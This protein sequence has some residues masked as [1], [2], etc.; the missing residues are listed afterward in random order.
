MKLN[1]IRKP[2]NINTVIVETLSSYD[3]K[4]EILTE[5]VRDIIQDVANWIERK[6]IKSLSFK[7]LRNGGNHITA[8]KV[9]DRVEVA[10]YD[11]SGIIDVKTFDSLNESETYL[12]Q[13][14]EEGYQLVSDNREIKRAVGIFLTAVGLGSIFAASWLF[15]GPALVFLY[16]IISGLIGVVA[17]VVGTVASFLGSTIAS[18]A[19]GIAGSQTGGAI[20]SFMANI[21]VTGATIAAGWLTLSLG[22]NLVNSTHEDI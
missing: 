22:V 5:G 13:K 3:T 11:R 4:Q 15:F 17:S 10:E 19:G 8:S 6:R 16:G 12:N 1:E 20:A 9:D 7:F 21:V 14:L 2:Q 18:I